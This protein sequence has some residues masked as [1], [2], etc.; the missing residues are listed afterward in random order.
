MRPLGA[1]GLPISRRH[2]SV[3]NQVTNARVWMGSLYRGAT[4]RNTAIQPTFLSTSGIK[5]FAPAVSS[6]AEA[7]QT[8][9]IKRL[10]MGVPRLADISA[11]ASPKAIAARGRALGFW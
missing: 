11:A 6:P 7:L 4:Q 1:M 10:K 5:V 2:S 9:P 8:C 3:S